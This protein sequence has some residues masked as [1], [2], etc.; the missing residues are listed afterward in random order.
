MATGGWEALRLATEVLDEVLD[1]L[2]EDICWELH[3]AV[4][5]GGLSASQLWDT[6]GVLAM[7]RDVGLGEGGG[8]LPLVLPPQPNVACRKCGRHI[9]C[10]RLASHLERCLAMSSQHHAGGAGAFASSTLGGGLG[11]GTAGEANNSPRSPRVQAQHRNDH[12]AMGAQLGYGARRESARAR[13]QA[14]D[15]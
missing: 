5:T 1:E 14:D 12:H 10:S 3:R 9:G 11:G 15:S 13:R 8:V 2:S 6:D 7:E 4:K